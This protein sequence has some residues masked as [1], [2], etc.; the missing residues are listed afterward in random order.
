MGGRHYHRCWPNAINLPFPTPEL[1]NDIQEACPKVNSFDM[2]S[3]VTPPRMASAG[4]EE[5]A[6][7]AGER[8]ARPA[9][10]SE[11]QIVT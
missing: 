9:R 3:N 1:S 10:H 4:R 7:L 6:T 2:A 8:F 5:L 11:I